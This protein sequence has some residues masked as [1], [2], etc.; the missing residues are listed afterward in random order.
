MMPLGG[1]CLLMMQAIENSI[2]VGIGRRLGNGP[3]TVLR[4]G[5]LPSKVNFMHQAGIS[6]AEVALSAVGT[7]LG[8]GPLILLNFQVSRISI[9]PAWPNPSASAQVSISVSQLFWTLN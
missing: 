4:S 3:A 7:L 1:S 5:R 2:H 9:P 6:K 8:Y